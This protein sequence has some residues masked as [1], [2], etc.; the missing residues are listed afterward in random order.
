MRRIMYVLTVAAL[1]APALLG[2]QQF[3]A[4]SAYHNGEIFLSEPVNQSDAATIYRY[5]QTA[6]GWTET[7]TLM[8][9][10]HEGGDYFGRFVAVDDQSLII[11]STLYEGSTGAVWIYQ[12]DGA[13]WEFVEMMRPDDVAEGESFGRFGLLHGDLLFVSALGH[14]ESR[15]AVWVFQRGPGGTWVQEAKLEPGAETTEQEFFGWSLAFDGE[16]LLTGALQASQDLENRGAAYIF[17]RNG[18]GDWTL[19]TRLTLAEDE[20]EP[21]DT[22]GF[23]VGWLDGM[24]LIGT[25]GRDNGI[26]EIRTYRQ[27]GETWTPG[28][29]LSAYERAQGSRFGTSLAFGDGELWVGAPGAHASG[30]VY[31]IQYDA[32]SQEFGS[33]S[34]LAGLEADV[35]DNFGNTITLAGDLAIVG[36]TGD[37][38]GMGSAVILERTGGS[39]AA[40]TKLAGPDPTSMEPLVAGEITCTGGQ[41]DQFTC[42]QVDIASFLPVRDIGGG[43]GAN[44]NDVWGWT[45]PESRREYAI[46]GRTDGTAFIDVTDAAGPIYLG[47]LPKTEGSRGN[48]WRDIK[49]YNNHAFI[50]ADGAGQHGMQIF[51]LTRLRNVPNAPATFDE[52][53]HYDGIASAHNIVVN[54]ATGYAY[55]VGVNSGGETCGGGLHMINVQQPTHP[56]FEGCFSDTTSGNSGTGYSH[57]AQCIIYDGPDTEYVG[58]EICF[59]S[60]ENKL[61][62]ADLSDKANPNFIA[63]ASYPN[64]GYAHQGWVTEDHKYFY[65]NDEGD[66]MNAVQA[67]DSLPG[68]R[69]LIWD[70]QDLDDPLMVKEHFGE[71]FTIDH[72]LYIKGNLMYQSNYVSGL[73]ILDI[74]DPENPEEVGF[75]DTVPWSEEVEFDGSWSN[76]PYFESGTIVVSSGAEGVFFVKYRPVD[77]VP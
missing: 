16:R 41:A 26:G 3:G 1:A 37:D 22:F 53:A 50:V 68:T 71:T 32:V 76:Y 4:Y 57:D 38:F 8:A 47:N 55:A 6:A 14:N 12:R 19:E 5:S 60:N 15:G 29:S 30:R 73:R 27:E 20:S 61:S 65:M 56:V 43:R 35:G 11:G 25:P 66:E 2:A 45:D 28:I 67:G 33:V 17:R 34:K 13:D 7:G 69:T 24:A 64:V 59:G 18:P 46:V 42:N 74:S 54:E 70:I 72:N 31:R 52:D 36:A 21:G 39:W 10:G 44:V 9:P 63:S 51:D 58:K 62:I 48:S 40:T 49:V 75:L 77:L 23:V